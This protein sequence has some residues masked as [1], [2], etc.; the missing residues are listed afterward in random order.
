MTAAWRLVRIWNTVALRNSRR[1]APHRGGAPAAP[2]PAPTPV[3]SGNHLDDADEWRSSV[4]ESWFLP[5]D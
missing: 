4:N 2:A 1:R 3:S 5:R